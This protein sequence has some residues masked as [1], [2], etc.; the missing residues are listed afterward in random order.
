M[1]GGGEHGAGA[2]AAGGEEGEVDV[3]EDEHG[4]ERGG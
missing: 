3:K 2:A 1:A 4:G